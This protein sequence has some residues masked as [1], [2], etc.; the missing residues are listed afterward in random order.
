MQL[1][2]DA[3]SSQLYRRLLSYIDKPIRLACTRCSCTIHDRRLESRQ[4]SYKAE[5]TLVAVP[6]MHDLA[7]LPAWAT[8]NVV[9]IPQML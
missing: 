8:D 2:G 5:N 4:N 3:E 9:A 1:F 6:R 7:R